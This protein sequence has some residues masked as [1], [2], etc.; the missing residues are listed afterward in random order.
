MMQPPGIP[1]QVPLLGR[2]GQSQQEQDQQQQAVAHQMVVSCYL[3]L[4]PV[5]A[6]AILAHTDTYPDR[7]QIP[8][9]IAE[10]AW[11][12][13]GAVVKRLGITIPEERPQQNSAPTTD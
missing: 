7:E 1:F 10:E 8:E 9:R 2:Q 3:S 4:V 12:V 11:R 6:G 13:T 5:V